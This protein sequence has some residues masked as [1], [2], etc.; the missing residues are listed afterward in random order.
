MSNIIVMF[1][2]LL[3]ATLVVIVVML[4]KLLSSSKSKNDEKL[5]ELLN[6]NVL[7]VRQ[8]MDKN[9]ESFNQRLDKAAQVIGAVNRELGSMSEIGRNIKDFQALLNAPKLR[10]NLG[11]TILY[12]TLSQTL[13]SSHYETQFKFKAGQT[14]DAIIKTNSGLICVD[15]KF[16]M[17][18]F[19]LM[20]KAQ[21]PKEKE[22]QL[23][24]FVR[25]VK[26]H[27]DDIQDKYILPAEG[28]LEYAIMY[29]PSEKVFYEIVME[30]EDLLQYA[31]ERHIMPVSPN[32]FL[33]YLRTILMGLERG[34]IQEEAKH[35]IEVLKGIQN[36]NKRFG[37]A[38]LLVSR[39]LTNAKNAMDNATNQYDTFSHR[40]N[41]VQ[42]LGSGENKG[43]D[44]KKD[45]I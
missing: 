3:L 6:Q 24:D 12:D 16:P 34:K 29:V 2:A 1:S 5:F 10:G 17:E 44:S 43:L 33:Y 30:S 27:I 4:Q 7:G 45:N 11:E 35:I 18:N 41:Q 37:E 22:R 20:S 19:V 42:L 28:T 21:D 31:H 38:I 36:E 26:K 8:Q 23:K 39:H 14:V 9:S 13:P 15:S 40:I 25:Q 32:T